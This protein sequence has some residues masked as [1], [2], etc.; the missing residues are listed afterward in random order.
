MSKT[1]ILL[2]ILVFFVLTFGSFI[3][4]IATWD[5]DKEESMSQLSTLEGTIT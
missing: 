2:M 4:M 1:R 3:W 5:A